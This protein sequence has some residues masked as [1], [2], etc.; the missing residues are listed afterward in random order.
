MFLKQN[1]NINNYHK[2]FVKGPF[3]I[4]LVFIY[5]FFLDVCVNVNSDIPQQSP[6]VSTIKQSNSFIYDSSLESS[7]NT[8]SQDY[9]SYYNTRLYYSV[10]TKKDLN[11][12]EKKNWMLLFYIMLGYICYFNPQADELHFSQEASHC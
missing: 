3:Q 9:S 11:F 8:C 5:G 1:E 2:L 10:L 6:N 7:A 12:W 4:L